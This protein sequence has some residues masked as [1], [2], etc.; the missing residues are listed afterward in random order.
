MKAEKDDYGDRLE[1]VH[2]IDKDVS[3]TAS[4]AVPTLLILILI[5]ICNAI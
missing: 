1:A 5:L 2:V 3:A 4:M